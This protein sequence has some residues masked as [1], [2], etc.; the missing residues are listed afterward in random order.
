[1]E[2]EYG[3]KLYILEPRTKPNHVAL[4]KRCTVLPTINRKSRELRPKT[5][6]QSHITLQQAIWIVPI[7]DT[8]CEEMRLTVYTEKPKERSYHGA[9]VDKAKERERKPYDRRF[10][11][12][13][14]G[15]VPLEDKAMVE[16]QGPIVDRTLEHPGY[17]DRAILL[18]RKMIRDGIAEVANGG[19]PKGV[20]KE[21]LPV[22]DLDIGV[23][24]YPVGQVPQQAKELIAEL[25][26]QAAQI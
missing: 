16:S 22:V 6:G 12:E 19:A 15:I 2:G 8:H 5:P 14:K 3:V 21:D 26:Q 9:Y 24:E 4:R 10:Y 13:I 17:G 18:L 11:G 25:Q 1:V 7:D 20:L 23:E